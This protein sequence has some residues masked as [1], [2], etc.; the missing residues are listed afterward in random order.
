MSKYKKN[1]LIIL[2]KSLHEM[3]VTTDP[4]FLKDS[5]KCCLDERLTLPAGKKM[6]DPFTMD[7]S[8]DFSAIGTFGLFFN[9]MVEKQGR[10]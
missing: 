9:Q 3:G 7:K 1:D 5:V 10:L 6:P 2:A 4:D 8:S